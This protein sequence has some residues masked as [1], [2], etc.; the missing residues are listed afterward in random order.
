MDAVAPPSRR[1]HLRLVTTAPAR[2]PRASAKA[3]AR[4]EEARARTAF[5]VFASALAF[6]VVLGGVRV[7]LITQ[8]AEASLSEGRIQAGIK[9]QRAQV[10]QLEVDRSALSTPSRIAGIATST[11]KMTEPRAVHYISLPGVVSESGPAVSAIPSYSSALARAFGVVID[12]SA[13]EAQS[14]LVGD[15]GLAGSR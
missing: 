14:L 7:A 8:A 6:A 12:L 3:R 4:A 9:A 15:L 13:G 2:S 10:D 5:A 11:M 1:D